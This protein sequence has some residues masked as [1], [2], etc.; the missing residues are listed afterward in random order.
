MR[1]GSQEGHLTK[2][3]QR[4]GI[5]VH[6]IDGRALIRI[7]P[8][9]QWTT[10][11][12]TRD[13]VLP[14]VT[15]AREPQL[16][17]RVVPPQMLRYRDN[18]F[19]MNFK[20]RLFI[21]LWLAGAAGVLSFLLVDLAALLALL[22]VPA[23]M[24]MP[25]ITPAIKLLSLI[26]PT[27][28]LSVA[29]LIGV[30]LASKV[31]L[32]SPVAEAMAGNGDLRSALKPQIIPGLIGGLVGGVAII[33]NWLLWKPFLPPAF[34]ARSVELNKLLPLPTR[35]L[36][37]GFTEELLLR[38]GLM[39]LLVW[40]AWRLFQKKQGEP[41][42][43]YFISAIVASSV[44]FGL[45]HLPFIF[46]IVPDPSAAL[47]LYVIVGNATFGLIVGYLYWKKGLESAIIAHMVAHVV[48]LI[49][50]FFEV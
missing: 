1:I 8:T 39:T 9:S 29:V 49:A 40:A 6:L 5:S 13:L 7:L 15:R 22:P 34:V 50:I 25:R 10:L 32:S 14:S 11:A 18:A 12:V 42:T 4:T 21:I 16:K 44:V 2:R 48:M 33:L 24:E 19:A 26:Q 36:Y 43:G 17:H 41:Q 38:W 35:L 45:G 27:V 20:T 47:I 28:L 3:F 30:S 46:A 37:G 23:G 31:S